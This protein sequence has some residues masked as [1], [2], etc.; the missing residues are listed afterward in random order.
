MTPELS[1]VLA[2]AVNRDLRDPELQAA[3]NWVIEHEG[4]IE[5]ADDLPADIRAAL[6]V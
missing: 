4:E 3:R 6:G 5:T 1:R 2:R